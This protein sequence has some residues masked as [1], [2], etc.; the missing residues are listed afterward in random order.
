M[1][2][3][4]LSERDY[5]C[6]LYELFDTASLT[7]RERYQD[8][9]RQPFDQTIQTAKIIAEKFFLPI[10]QKL[11][12]EQS[13]FDGKTI[14]QP[15]ELKPALEAVIGAGFNSPCANYDSGGCSFQLSSRMVGSK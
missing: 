2:A 13:T 12:V 4:L 15:A 6:M 10:R 7:T 3:E 1:S 8:H 11:D 14:Q 9:D 5:Q